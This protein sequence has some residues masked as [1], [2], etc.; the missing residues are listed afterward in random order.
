MR[1]SKSRRY[2]EGEGDLIVVV[3][4]VLFQQLVV[5]TTLVTSCHY[6]FLKSHFSFFLICLYLFPHNTTTA[7]D[8]FP[9]FLCTH[10][11]F[12]F[13]VLNF[14]Q[15]VNFYNKHFLLISSNT[16]FILPNCSTFHH[17]SCLQF[18]SYPTRQLHPTT[19][20]GV[21]SVT[22]SMLEIVDFY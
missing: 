3:V 16:F 12:F 10:F 4:V 11:L 7:F 22:L 5:S 8:F 9:T 6:Y 13:S 2:G 19:H 14:Q 17:N 20:L 21:M 15:I 18:Y 1:I